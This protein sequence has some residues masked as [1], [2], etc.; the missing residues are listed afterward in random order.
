MD[1]NLASFTHS[2]L[3]DHRRMNESIAALESIVRT[4]RTLA[5]A[6]RGRVAGLVTDLRRRIGRHFAAEEEGGLFE[7]IERNA[8]EAAESC[9]RLRAQHAAILTALDRS[10]TE[11]PPQRASSATLESWAASARAVLVEVKSHE[12]LEDA[13]LLAALEGGRGAPD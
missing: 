9:A 3:E 10:L 1:P 8:P 7:Q 4:A 13:L 12:E 6:P 2:V 5:G 11:L